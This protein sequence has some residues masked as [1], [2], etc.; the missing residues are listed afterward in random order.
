MAARKLA[1]ATCSALAARCHLLT[2]LSNAVGQGV[3]HEAESLAQLFDEPLRVVEQ[4]RERLDLRARNL[5]R[6]AD[7]RARGGRER[8]RLLAVARQ[9]CQVEVL[10]AAEP[11]AGRELRVSTAQP[12]REHCRVVTGHADG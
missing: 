12:L 7:G 1:T 4:L 6:E 5:H 9:R 10:V 8:E 3:G 2:A 11:C